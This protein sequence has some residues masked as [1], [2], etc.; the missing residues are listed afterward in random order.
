MQLPF[1]DA[2]QHVGPTYSS[3]PYMFG[4]ANGMGFSESYG[5]NGQTPSIDAPSPSYTVAPT[6]NY[7]PTQF[8]NPLA[9]SG[10]QPSAPFDPAYNSMLNYP[11]APLPSFTP[12]IPTAFIQDP[13]P[14]SPPAPAPASSPPPSRYAT[15]ASI[16]RKRD[17]EA[18][19]FA[20]PSGSNLNASSD[21]SEK[22]AKRRGRPRKKAKTTAKK[23][24]AEV[25]P[26]I[27]NTDPWDY[28]FDVSSGS[29]SLRR[30]TEHHVWVHQLNAVA[31]AKTTWYGKP[32]PTVPVC[33]LPIV[34]G[35]AKYGYTSADKLKVC[36][37]EGCK[38]KAR[39]SGEGQNWLRHHIEGTTHLNLRLMC[40]LCGY[41]ARKDLFRS[42]ATSNDLRHGMV[43]PTGENGRVRMKLHPLYEKWRD[44][45]ELD[46]IRA[47]N[48]AKIA[49]VRAQRTAKSS[50]GEES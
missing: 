27:T 5:L 8:A 28:S 31:R 26:R 32:L 10:L 12:S 20:S 40:L 17:D 6:G 19:D 7:N 43:C 14:P 24:R 9:Y 35:S 36:G 21:N 22:T 11:I 34:L 1:G 3:Q 47:E 16:K 50:E 2:Y 48:A 49:E 4:Q 44:S 29:Q 38:A 18:A 15:R 33:D 46:E 13:L 39:S 45:G 25:V 23:P 42:I 30:L 41:S 37:F